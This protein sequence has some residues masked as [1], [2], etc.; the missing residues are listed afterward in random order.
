MGIVAIF[1]KYSKNISELE[2]QQKRKINDKN[3][4]EELE[5]LELHESFLF[6]SSSSQNRKCQEVR[7]QLATYQF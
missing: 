2:R 3:L 1:K 6:L 4:I 7:C 5:M